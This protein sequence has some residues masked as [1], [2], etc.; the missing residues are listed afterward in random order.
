MFAA[1]AAALGFT[2]CNET[3]DDN[4]VLNFHEGDQVLNFLNEP[5]MQNMSVD[6]TEENAGESFLLTCSQPKEYGYAASVAYAVEVSI[7][8]DFKAP[9]GVSTPGSVIFST[10]Y[11]D[12]GNIHPTR[13]DV[14]EALCKML[15][16]K[17]AAQIPTA[18]TPVYAR[19]HA[20]VVNENG[21]PVTQTVNVD[22]EEVT[23]GTTFTSNTVVL[24]KA[25]SC[26]YLAIV[27]PDLPTGYY[28]RGELNDWLNP[29]FDEG[30]PE[31]I[32]NL[33]NY[34][35]KTTTES[36]T[37]ELDYIEIPAASKFKFADK[38]GGDLNLGFGNGEPILG[39]KY[40]LGW[41][42]SDMT[43]PSA[44]KGSITLMGSG[45]SW[46]AI[47]YPM[48]SDTPGQPSGLYLR[49]GL[50][51]WG[52]DDEFLTTDVKGIWECPN[53]TIPAGTEFKVADANWSEVDLG[54]PDGDGKNVIS[55]GV[56]YQ[57]SIGGGNIKIDEAF[58]GNAKL[59]KKGN[60]YSVTLE[61][62]Q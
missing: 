36:N 23:L 39:Q 20:N 17:E 59:I 11:R 3:W 1:F 22:G 38:N 50:N 35:F 37:Y 45:Q 32:K 4:P 44:F 34:E 24:C 2:A 49:G 9:E 42:G 62:I 14:A 61:P 21:N 55:V 10:T 53:V 46:S 54:A 25:V 51:G 7:Y 19:L 16:I 27:V 12:C 56:K 57:L 43:L 33:P 40:E 6:I 8:E 31:A 41:S 28:I 30:N 18:Y 5:E 26:A 47:F 60:K 48:E 29:A 13:R 58:T 15:D 52:T